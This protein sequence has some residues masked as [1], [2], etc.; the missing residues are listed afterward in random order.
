VELDITN[1]EY[2]EFKQEL[3]ESRE[4]I[5]DIEFWKTLLTK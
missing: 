5:S 4:K 1:E 2:E 3:L